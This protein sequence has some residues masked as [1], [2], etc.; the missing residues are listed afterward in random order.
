M[1][2]LRTA[3]IGLVDLLK[4]LRIRDPRGRKHLAG[5]A[6]DARS[7]KILPGVLRQPRV[8]FPNGRFRTGPTKMVYTQQIEAIT[9]VMK[10]VRYCRAFSNVRRASADLSTSAP[11]K[12]PDVPEAQAQHPDCADDFARRLRRSWARLIKKVQETHHSQ[13]IATLPRSLI[14]HH[15]ALD[16]G[17]KSVGVEAN[18]DSADL[19]GLGFML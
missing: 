5:A 11:G 13:G 7:Q 3:W 9:A 6:P 17:S 18:Q 12:E 1:A 10:L 15:R 19:G 8:L 14:L 16:L 4:Y 2:A